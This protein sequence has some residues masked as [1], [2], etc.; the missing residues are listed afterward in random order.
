MKMLEDVKRFLE[1]RLEDFIRQNPWIELHILDEQLEQQEVEVNK[2]ILSFDK[3]EKLLQQQILA[4]AEDVSL[5]HRRA[6]KA[7]EANRPDLAKA[8][9]AREIALLKEGNQLWA[10]MELI[11]QRSMQAQELLQQ[12]KTRR[13]E[14]RQK[15]Q[16]VEQRKQTTD[17]FDWQNLRPPDRD[18][19]DPL[20]QQFRRWELDEELQELKRKM[21]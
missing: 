12:I 5:W 19:D 7:R 8:A 17:R 18:E 10:Q 14:V 2:L 13:Q 6:K 1:I 16:Q 15:L 3:Q 4:L 11:K 20:E 9:E 21:K